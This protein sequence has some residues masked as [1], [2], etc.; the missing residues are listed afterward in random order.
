MFTA[1]ELLRKK[2]AVCRAL[3][4]EAGCT[5]LMVPTVMHHYLVPE[6]QAQEDDGNVKFNAHLGKFTNF[7]NLL[8]LAAVAIP[9]SILPPVHEQVC[10]MHYIPSDSRLRSARTHI[11]TAH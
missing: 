8:G 3:M 5:Y 1:Q 2:V 9:A 7:V 11:I 4:A 10:R 6:L